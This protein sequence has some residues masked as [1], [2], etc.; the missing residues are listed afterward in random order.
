MSTHTT[1]MAAHRRPL[2]GFEQAVERALGVDMRLLYGMGVPVIGV[3]VVIALA[4]GFAASPWVVGG[5]L[6]LEVVVLCVVLTGFWGLL[7]D[8]DDDGGAA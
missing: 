3:S 4:F 1:H 7:N 6:A 5:V 2:R 8:D